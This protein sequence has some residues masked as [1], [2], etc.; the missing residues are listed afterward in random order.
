M[1]KKLEEESLRKEQLLYKLENNLKEIT[2][3]YDL[4][5]DIKISNET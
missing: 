3:K 2:G 1:K 5:K 4:I